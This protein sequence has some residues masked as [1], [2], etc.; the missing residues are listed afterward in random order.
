MQYCNILTT[1]SFEAPRKIRRLKHANRRLKQANQSFKARKTSFE[2][3][4]PVARIT[5]A[6]SFCLLICQY[7]Q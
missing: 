3:R 6:R 7:S 4:K 5:S 2:A 1:F